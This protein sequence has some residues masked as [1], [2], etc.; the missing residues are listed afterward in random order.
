MTKILVYVCLGLAVL[1]LVL[2]LLWRN[3]ALKADL[4]QAEA[5][6]ATVMSAYEAEHE[7]RMQLVREAEATARVLLERETELQHISDQRDAERRRW[8]EVLRDDQT[9]RDWADAPLPDAVRG[10]LR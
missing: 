2:G 10:M 7:V 9:A 1:G 6:L 4:A 5:D 3:A 8:Q